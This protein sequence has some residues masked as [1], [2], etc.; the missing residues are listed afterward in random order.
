M[1][2][3]SACLTFFRKIMQHEYYKSAVKKIWKYE[4]F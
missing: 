1:T 3:T 4:I 2:Y